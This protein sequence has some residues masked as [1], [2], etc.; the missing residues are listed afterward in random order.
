MKKCLMDLNIDAKETLNKA[1]SI[2]QDVISK[3]NK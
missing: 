1:T 3:N 2:M